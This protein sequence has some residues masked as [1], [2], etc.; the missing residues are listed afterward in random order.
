MTEQSRNDRL[1]YSTL[2]LHRLLNNG[3]FIAE[4][5]EVTPMNYSANLL[6]GFAIHA[7]DG[8]IGKV[9]ELYFDDQ[10]WIVRYLVVQTGTWLKSREVLIATPHL[11]HMDLQSK[12]IQVDLTREQVRQSPDTDTDMPVS[13]QHEELLHRYYGWPFYW[14]SMS[15]MPS[16]YDVWM[17]LP[18]GYKAP[19]IEGDPHL[20][21]TR[22]VEGYHIHAMD[23]NIGHV[24]RS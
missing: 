6:R 10:R 13:R 15:G 23:G 7:I 11:G 18:A 17:P 21:S 20:R 2:G 22:E 12:T 16:D 4:A 19:E 14:E 9:R 5:K 3:I 1:A 8:E 24:S